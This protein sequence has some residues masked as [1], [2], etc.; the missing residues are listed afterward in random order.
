MKLR[1]A[2]TF[3][4]K[5]KHPYKN[6]CIFI[7]VQQGDVMCGLI[8]PLEVVPCNS[9]HYATGELC[10]CAEYEPL[11]NLEY[12]EWRAENKKNDVIEDTNIW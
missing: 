4:R 10:G 7:F 5:C 12:L 9:T 11:D 1:K 8:K 3:C 2:D 6:H